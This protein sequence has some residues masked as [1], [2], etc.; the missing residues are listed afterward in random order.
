MQWE[1]CSQIPG[2]SEDNP[3]QR[4]GSRSTHHLNGRSNHITIAP[5]KHPNLQN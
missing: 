4:L 3:G 1:P 5:G 2:S